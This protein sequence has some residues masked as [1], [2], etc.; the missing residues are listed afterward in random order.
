MSEGRGGRFGPKTPP[1]WVR[2]ASPYRGGDA[3]T[4]LQPRP[5][6]VRDALGTHLG[7]RDAPRTHPLLTTPE[8][9]QR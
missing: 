3:G 8:G 9:E 4:H 5:A 6:C 1:V 2:P 7:R